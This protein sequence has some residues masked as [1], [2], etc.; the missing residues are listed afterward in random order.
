ML[1]LEQ[2]EQAAA[3]AIQVMRRVD[4]PP[5][6]NNYQVWFAYM[7]REKPRLCDRIDRLME[8]AEPFT[9][10]LMESL[11]ADFFTLHADFGVVS[12]KM[13]E[14]R[15]VAVDLVD[16][17]ATSKVAIGRYSLVLDTAVQALNRSPSKPTVEQTIRALQTA[18]ESA[19]ERI[20][21]L[22]HLFAASVAR[23]SELQQ[24]LMS[25]EKDAHTD[26][27][28][29]LANRRAFEAALQARATEMAAAG[30]AMTLLLL[31]VDNFKRFNDM[32]GHVLG[33]KLLQLFSQ[34]LTNNIKGRD[35]AARYGGEEFA[36]ILVQANVRQATAVAEQIRM[37]LS[38]APIKNRGTGQSLGVVTCSIGIAAYRQGEPLTDLVDRADRALYEAKRTGRNRVAVEPESDNQAQNQAQPVTAIVPAAPVL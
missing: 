18:T 11:Y 31:D 28:T 37:I 25:S 35:L 1:S 24:E 10:E 26:Q 16:R 14:L 3:A 15:G 12:G 21:T 34:I 33:D 38:S 8:A 5:T 29:G 19:G 7:T 22:E 30:Y 17:L 32:H 4:V 20:L 23:I 9:P 6:P 13:R 36:I 27:L 2:V